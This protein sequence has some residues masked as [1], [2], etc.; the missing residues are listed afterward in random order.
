M[1]PSHATWDPLDVHVVVIVLLDHP[2][3]HIVHPTIL[4]RPQAAIVL[5]PERAVHAAPIA[6]FLP[7]VNNIYACALTG[8]MGTTPEV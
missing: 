5:C 4:R 8:S 7:S 3:Q 6:L 2:P 1:R